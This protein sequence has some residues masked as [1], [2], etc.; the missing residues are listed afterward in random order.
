MN[1]GK[2]VLLY[3]L[4][5][6]VFFMIDMLWLGMVARGLYRKHL[7]GFLDDKVN[8]P[9]AIIFYLLFIIG[10]LI[11]AVLPAL[12]K[13]AFGT[14]LLLGGLF[15]F[16]TYAT[17]DLTNLATMKNWPMSIVWIDITWGI[18]LTG[19]VSALSFLIGK[20]IGLANPS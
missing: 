14:A 1:F 6:P 19:S 2:I 10:I 7:A 4:T 5:I 13:N 17:Y 3:L 11:F 20:W 18:L 16:F 9:A 12:G 15:G 8:W